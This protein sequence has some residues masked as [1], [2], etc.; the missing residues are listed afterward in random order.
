MPLYLN[1][2]QTMLRESAQQFVAE[3][4]PVS[5]MRALRD[6]NDATGFS[7]DL[8]KQF[9]EMGFTGILIPEADGGLGLG[10]VEAGVVLEEI[11]RNLSPSPFLTTAVAAVAALKGTAQRERWFPGILSGET[12]AALAIDERAKHGDA[13]G[14][15]AERSGNGFRL[16]GAKQFV[17]HG[18]VADLL[19]VAARTAGSPEDADG[20]TL[21]A[22]PKDAANPTADPQRLADASLAARMTFDGVEVD[23]DAVIGEVDGG[24]AVLNALLG[25][26]R[27]GA[28][29]EMLGVG[30]GA[31][32][33]T[34]QYLKERKQFGVLI[35][36]FQALQHRAA[37]LYSELEVARAAVLKAQQLLDAGD[38]KAD[39][40]VSVAKAM[41]G[42]ASTLAVQEGVQM[43]GGIGM[44]DEYDIGFYMKRGRVLAELFGD[45]NY[46]ADALARA[47]GY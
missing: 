44:T 28:A 11:G 3:A 35:G 42:M 41:A 29:A 7:R 21:F 23:A 32:D 2:E 37:H 25:A 18:H 39:E 45:T 4:A 22:V 46:H 36:S 9:A 24:R 27:T 17:A 38:A 34:V 14:M 33:M 47:A 43:H 10:H 12:V 40:A 26:G 15:K 13:I 6:A 30:G 1:D 5:H 8:W 31:M 19:I 16:T 20:V